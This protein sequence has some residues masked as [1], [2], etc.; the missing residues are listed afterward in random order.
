[1]RLGIMQPYFAPALGYF[2]LISLC[3]KWVVFDV[4]DFRPKSWMVRNRILH[5]SS[6]WQFIKAKT[7]KVRRGTPIRD[8][9]LAPERDWRDLIL[10][11]V[12]HYR[13]RAPYFEDTFELLQRGLDAD[14]DSLAKLSTHILSE[15]CLRLDIP[16]SHSF[17]SEMNLPIGPIQGP[18]DWAL[19][20]SEAMGATEYVNPP[21]GRDLFDPDAFA[22]AGVKLTIREFEELHYQPRGYE[23]IPMLSVFDVMMWCPASA[24]SEHLARARA[25]FERVER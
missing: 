4:T 6:G 7:G 10:R 13:K 11:Q 15:V 21:G 3:D 22:K 1:M 19:R 24:I 23:F 9:R 14:T 8:V 20:I 5:P 25:D 12:E 16:F 18:G 17:L 2:D